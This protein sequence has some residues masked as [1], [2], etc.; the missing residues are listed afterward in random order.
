MLYGIWL[1]LYTPTTSIVLVKGVCS[2]NCIFSVGIDGSI[3]VPVFAG[4]WSGATKV[5]VDVEEVYP[6]PY[7]LV[8]IY[9]FAL[10]LSTNTPVSL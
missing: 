2:N 7:K 9:E 3:A 8:L 6:S 4:V 5:P 10:L 1:N